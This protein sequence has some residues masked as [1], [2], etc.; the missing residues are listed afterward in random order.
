MVTGFSKFLF[1][2][3]TL[4]TAWTQIVCPQARK[5]QIPSPWLSVRVRLLPP[6]IFI[7]LSKELIWL[8]AKERVMLALAPDV[9]GFRGIC[10][11]FWVRN[12]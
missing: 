7:L 3:F 12:T 5:R 9:I 10:G 8:K 1:P 11:A 6:P 4:K 2:S